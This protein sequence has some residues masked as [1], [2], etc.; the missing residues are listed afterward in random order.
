MDGED[1]RHAEERRVVPVEG[2][3][4]HGHE[5]G[6][7]VVGVEDARPLAA[8]PEVLDRRAREEGEA[9]P[10]VAVVAVDDVAVEEGRVLD[11]H[12]LDVRGR[13]RAIE[14]GAARDAVDRDVDRARE[15]ARGEGDPAV[16]REHHR[17]AVA[18]P[19]ERLRQRARDVGEAAGLDERRHL[20]RHERHVQ[21]FLVGQRV[22][23]A[24]RLTRGAARFL[25]YAP[26]M[27]RRLGQHFLRPASVE[28][29][30]RVI[31]PGPADVFLEI[32]PGQGALTLPLARQCGAGGR[33]RARRARSPIAC[34]STLRR[35]SRS[36]RPTPSR[37]TCA[38]SCPRAAASSAT[39]PTTSRA[40]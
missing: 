37:P 34:A 1:A 23:Q 28:K 21:A 35:T 19:H 40:R 30:L 31:A 2:L 9:Q 6:L 36:S 29:L 22:S 10:V 7:P 5:A 32:G 25:S 24:W 4:V 14:A 16:A 27:P 13:A 39:C 3:Q 38:R 26:R 17:D 15:L 33:G 20:G 12:H 8:A 18:E 11:E